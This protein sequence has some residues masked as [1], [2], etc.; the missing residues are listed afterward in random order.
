MRCAEKMF[1][2]IKFLFG[3]E[4]DTITCFCQLTFPFKQQ[5]SVSVQYD[6]C[7]NNI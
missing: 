2:D 3:N 7:I 6:V 5:S 1:N 4:N